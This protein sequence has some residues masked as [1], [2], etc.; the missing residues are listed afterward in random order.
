MRYKFRQAKVT[1]VG[2]ARSGLAAGRLLKHIGAEVTVIDSNDSD[3][4]RKNQKLLLSEGI[5]AQIGQDEQEFVE[6]SDIIVISPGVSEDTPFIRNAKQNYI[7]VIS[8]MEL[9][10]QNCPATVIAVTGTNGKT[11]VT[12]LIGEVL[13]ANAK[14]AFVGG[15]IGVPFSNFA[16]TATKDDYAVLEVSSFQ[17]EKIDEFRPFI[18]VILNFT[19][20]HLDRYKSIDDYLT[21]KKRIYLNQGRNDWVV[22]NFIDS[23]LKGLKDEIKANVIFFN[24]PN[25]LSEK[26]LNPNQR[27]VFKVASILKLDKEKCL[28]V[29]RQF[30][31]IAHRMEFVRSLSGVDFINDSKATNTDS[32][33]W[34]LERIT[35]PIILIA[36]GKDK[37]FDFSLIRDRV[38]EKVKCMYVIGQTKEKLFN[39]FNKDTLVYKADSLEQ[40][41]QSAF[42]KSNAGDC[43]ILSPMCSSFDMFRDYE[44]RG[45]IFRD[46]VN[47]LSEKQ[48]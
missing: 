15:N 19:P 7:P 47:Q 5:L 41:I 37:G 1:V 24:Q 33:I 30:K 2:M 32:T 8:E 23:T 11:T 31:G 39:I 3:I 34:A 48:T 35:K 17:L 14:K 43:V 36:G 6:K 25:D 21:A 38:K 10:Y 16:L 22:L 44:Q 26:D 12:T 40:A 9:A 27:C 13:K 4:L 45:D 18:S 42:E 46:F 20:D 29:F 28:E